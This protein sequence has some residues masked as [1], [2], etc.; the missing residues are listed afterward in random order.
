[1][2]K[3]YLIP[4]VISGI[5]FLLTFFLF[6]Y[7]DLTSL[8]V[9][10]INV[11]D[12]LYETHNFR[13]FYQFSA[14]N[15]FELDHAMVGS[16]FLIYIPWAIWNFP[17]WIIQKFFN[18]PAAY[19]AFPQL[20]SKVFLVLMFGLCIIPLKRISNILEN[21]MEDIRH[22]LFRVILLSSTSFFT[23][24]SLAYAGQNDIMAIFPFLMAFSFLLEG[25]DKKF[26]VWAA[27]SIA[28]KPFFVFSYVAIILLK[29]KNLLRILAKV[30]IGFSIYF[31]QKVPFIN[32]YQYKESLA[33]GPT[34]GGIKLLLQATIDIP[35]AGASLFF[36]TLGALYLAIY[37]MDFEPVEDRALYLTYSATAPLII[38]FMFTRY[39]AYRP[40]YLVPMLYLL[41]MF[42]PEYS[43]LNLLLETVSTG[44]LMAFYLL[45]DVLFYNPNY[46]W[47]KSQWVDYPS[48]SGFLAEKLP[49]FG[50]SLFAACYTLCMALI[51]MINHPKFKSENKVL[52]MEEE[53]W[54][55]P[56][57]SMIYA[58]PLMLSVAIKIIK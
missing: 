24:T 1:M 2:N 38:F 52:R 47:A 50:Y 15:L 28:F 56:V 22:K 55:L 29:E 40:F 9:W 51:L 11:W 23:V 18:Y 8:T 44:C 4:G 43:R 14:M 53:K 20:W 35:P 34:A 49:G 26:Y 31:L 30:A 46:I 25:K 32:A 36:L 48:V 54:L 42:K 21:S 58:A 7:T 10:T 12:N 19:H 41:M 37:F 16:D 6:L 27:L 5:T 3:K 13:S 17:L 57:R 45:D 33:Y 39:E